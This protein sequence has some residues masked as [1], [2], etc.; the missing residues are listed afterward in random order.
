[1]NPFSFLYSPQSR[2]VVREYTF[3]FALLLLVTTVILTSISAR[4]F[5]LVL[6][7]VDLVYLFICESLLH[8]IITLERLHNRL[9][10]VGR[11][12]LA[13]DLSFYP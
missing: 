7:I 2:R 5:R 12:Y 1:M 3:Y 10:H 4:T 11:F 9:N 6:R 13:C 8:T